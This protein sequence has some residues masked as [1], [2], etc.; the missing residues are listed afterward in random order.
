[1]R[2]SSKAFAVLAICVA[3]IVLADTMLQQGNTNLGPVNRLSC[4]SGVT[5]TKD[6]G[7]GILT[8][9]AD[10]FWLDAGTMVGVIGGAISTFQIYT[11]YWIADPDGGNPGL[12][13]SSRSPNTGI[14]TKPYTI[15][16]KGTIA[17]ANDSTT[18]FPTLEF[19]TQAG[20]SSTSNWIFAGQTDW[21]LTKADAGAPGPQVGL[22]IMTDNSLTFMPGPGGIRPF[23]MWGQFVQQGTLKLYG[24]S[25][26]TAL[27]LV[28]VGTALDLGGTNT[29]SATV[30]QADGGGVKQ[31]V[32]GAMQIGTLRLGS[33]PT[34][35]A[36]MSG[37][38]SGSLISDGGTVDAGV[39]RTEYIDLAGTTLG[40]NCMVNIW[41][42][43]PQVAGI[44]TTCDVTD[45]GHV[46]ITF[47]NYSN[48]IKTPTVGTYRALVLNH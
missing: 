48:D 27:E 25:S 44:V 28:N 6:G 38:F 33:D 43:T 7:Q 36:P 14:L 41:G 8:T 37:W 13:V 19:R 31:I 4:G 24:G 16:P 46:D 18:S 3:G 15:A 32:V 22:N 40:A 17:L 20:G 1:M 5:C 47:H 29:M 26:T 11:P 10:I 21:G 35:N 23:Q 2:K 42:S 39:S 12:R 30:L 45:A 34:L 9:N